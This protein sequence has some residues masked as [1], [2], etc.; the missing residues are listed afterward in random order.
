[1]DASLLNRLVSPDFY[2]WEQGLDYFAYYSEH[3]EEIEAADALL[4]DDR[5]HQVLHNLLQYKISRDP[6]LIAEIRDDVR[7]QYFDPKVIRFDKN[8]VFLDLGAYNGDTVEAFAHRVKG[9]YQKIVALEPD[10]RNYAQLQAVA[11]RLHDV[12]C[13]PYG[14][15]EMDGTVRFSANA[16]W[17]SSVAENGEIE[18]EIRS[19]DSLMAGRK[20]TFLK[21]DIE[22]LEK[23]MLA[24]A[25]HT[26]AEQAPQLAIA[27]YHCKEDIFGII[28]T[29][30]TD[31]KDYAFYLRHY[32]EM[33][34]DTVLYA[35]RKKNR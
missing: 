35:V 31:C 11:N 16:N 3:S 17:T 25:A 28:N 33:P 10:A 22:G 15:G 9:E 7:L 27:V 2:L 6:N 4:A 14:V 12:E 26:I 13:Y 32:T 1:M 21:A 5:S 24:G 20:L 8:E 34:I 23:E 18:I 30:H 19:V 29:I